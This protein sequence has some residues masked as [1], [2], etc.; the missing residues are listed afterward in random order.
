MKKD[1][2]RIVEVNWGQAAQRTHPIR[3]TVEAYDRSGLLRDI[4]ALVADERIN[5]RDAHATAGI[6]G[7]LARVTATLEIRDAEQLSRILT[8]IERLPNVT[9]ARR[10]H[11]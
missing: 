8:R 1:P 3:I 6:K 11:A 2:E 7:H 10:W 9:E 5:M 4:A